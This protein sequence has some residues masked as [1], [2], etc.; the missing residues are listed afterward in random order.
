MDKSL[1]FPI[2]AKAS[3]LSIG[4]YALISMLYF[5][6]AIILPLLFAIIIATVLRPIMT[7]LIRLKI[8]RVVAIAI[9]LLLTVIA[10]GAFCLFI[11]SQVKLFSASWPLLVEK[12]T[13]IW[14]RT[15]HWIPGFLD[16]SPQK[17]N[18][19]ISKTQSQLLNT[20]QAVIGQTILSVGNGIVIILLVPTY[21]FF[22]LLYQ[23]LLLDAIRKLFSNGNQIQVAEIM[24]QT[25][26]V[27]QRYLVGLLIEATIIAT[28]NSIGLLVLGI[29]YAILLGII[30]ALL[31]I[32]PYIGGLIAVALPMMIAIV[33][34]TPVYA[35]YVLAIH[36]SIQLIDNYFIVPKIVAS[37][38][39]IN[40]LVSIFVVLAGG[41]L[42][43]IPGMFVSIPLTAIVKVLFDHIDSMK[44]WGLLLG[45]TMPVRTIFKIKGKKKMIDLNE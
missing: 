31:N 23:P 36:Y 9:T 44:P 16:I 26:T 10:I 39:K 6:Q 13:H 27:V 24:T 30:G 1:K 17:L 40:A 38:V 11:F 12:F 25:K 15:I 14:N 19:W 28:L 37:K 33:T 32:I 29:D 41:A 4:L 43:G 21:V 8:N 2:Y 5:A 42:W 20:S 7:F 45:D 3:L 18:A 22:I 34:K 35:L